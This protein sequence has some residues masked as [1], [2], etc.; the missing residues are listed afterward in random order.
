MAVAATEAYEAAKEERLDAERAVRNLVIGN[1]TGLNNYLDGKGTQ[2]RDEKGHFTK[3][4]TFKEDIL[5]IQS[6]G[7][8]GSPE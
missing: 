4:T 5:N 6:A 7:E 2:S 1:N 3:Q 8:K